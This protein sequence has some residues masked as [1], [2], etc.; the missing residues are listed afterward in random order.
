MQN[1]GAK[2]AGT[3]L[4]KSGIIEKISLAQVQTAVAQVNGSGNANVTITTV[5]ADTPIINPN[6]GTNF[7]GMIVF[8]TEGQGADIPP[9]LSVF[10]PL[11]NRSQV[12]LN[13]YFGRQ[14]NSLNDVAVNP[15]NKAL[16]FTDTN[17]G[18]NQAFRPVPALPDQVYRFNYTT[19]LVSVVA[20]GFTLV[21]GLTFSPDG[22]YAYI[23]DTGIN[24]GF[25]EYN[26]SA[27]ATIYRYDVSD[28]GTFGNRQVFAFVSPGVADGIHC[29][30]Q[31]NVYV[32]PTH[33]LGT[34]LSHPDMLVAVTA[35][36]YGRQTA[37][38][39]GSFGWAPHRPTSNL[40]ARV[41][42]SS[43][44]RPSCIMRRWL[45]QALRSPTIRLPR[46][47]RFT[48]HERVFNVRNV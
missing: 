26:F 45:L 22:S 31:G 43:A 1:S 36:M 14:F 30:D 8:P 24:N 33:E 13:N 10:D 32:T 41:A 11:T 27:P 4:N 7:M 23:T 12:I 47:I 37:A 19:G 16:Y 17:Y 35:C 40:P 39:S 25:F 15:R 28:N 44:P 6:G 38:S 18:F 42:W 5:N 48:L 46:D 2:A 20:D 9:N 34:I 3:G 29:D 21:N